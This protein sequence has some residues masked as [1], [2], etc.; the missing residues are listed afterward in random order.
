MSVDEIV[1][2]IQNG[3]VSTGG[4]DYIQLIEQVGMIRTIAELI[5]GL[6][7]TIII[8]GLPVIIA[9]EI[10]YINF[11]VMQSSFNNILNKTSGNINRALGLVLRDAKIALTRANT[12]ETGR[13]VNYIYLLIKLKA[14]LIAIFS[15]GLVIG[16]G[17]IIVQLII[18]IASSIIEGFRGVI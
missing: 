11:P 16:V 17:P 13:D 4:A 8:I 12:V 18:K 2:D 15:V 6:F 10:C 5:L 7:V 3:I 9:L 1:N 14:I